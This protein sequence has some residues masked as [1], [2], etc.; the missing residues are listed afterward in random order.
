MHNIF[1][2]VLAPCCEPPEAGFLG[3]SQEFPASGGLIGAF[4]AYQMDLQRSAIGFC[5]TCVAAHGSVALK[6]K[7]PR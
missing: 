2:M 5:S 1:T 4:E 6:L 3:N 7:K